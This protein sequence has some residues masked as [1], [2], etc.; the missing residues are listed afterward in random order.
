M[1]SPGITGRRALRVL[2]TEDCRTD[3][4]LVA[5]M[6]E[7][8]PAR[9]EQQVVVEEAETLAA[10]LEL[11]LVG[12]ID[13]LL[14]DLQLPDADALVGLKQVLTAAPDLPVVVL[15][16]TDDADLAAR[17][18]SWGA[19]DYLVKGRVDVDGLLRTI[20][21][22]MERKEVQNALSQALSER[23]RALEQLSLSEQRFRR[24]FEDA[25]FGV[26]LGERAADGG[27]TVAE[28]NTEL[29]DLLSVT[30]ADLVGT[31]VL[32]RLHDDD[33]PAGLAWLDLLPQANQPAAVLEVRLTHPGREP[34]WTR[35]IGSTIRDQDG[36]AV[37]VLVQ[38]QDIHERRQAQD[39][40][41][42]YSFV[43]ALTNLPNRLLALDRINQALARAARTGRSI[44]VMYVDLDHFK[45]VNDSLGHG[46]GDELLRV[47]GARL[48]Q[49]V[50]PE[51]TVARI[52]GDE[53]VVCCDDLPAEAGAAELEAV[54]IAERMRHH[55][56]RPVSVGEHE[57][58]I[59]V[60]VGI[61]L[62]GDQRRTA[63][64]LLRDADTALYRAKD[65]GRSRWEVFDDALR[66][67]ALGRLETERALRQALE[68]VQLAVHYQPVLDLASGE[69]I[70]A[71][72][73][74]RWQH[75][76][77]GLLSPDEFIRIAEETGLIADRALGPGAGL[78]DPRPLEPHRG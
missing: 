36:S 51:D 45:V 49:A 53:F 75:P 29:A 71:E 54:S 77:A 76:S 15:T 73:L 4:R 6:L 3:R 62:S 23:T 64:E 44:A 19:Q 14:L 2:V 7:S 33:K 10:T 67:E 13:C 59:T 12:G 16:G 28:A 24:S 41:R 37:Q 74:L 40:L 50:R 70:G 27:W 56:E 66:E 11:L 32:R 8:G 69:V 31:D 78:R 68:R 60:S 9:S 5:A 35:L 17:A 30:S 21:H 48:P 38:V 63:D 46:V 55:L 52:G 61:A 58:A 57:L 1:S 18:L 34:T 42:D 22:A 26:L 47:V 43:D 65:N 72:A 20:R 25:P 39:Q